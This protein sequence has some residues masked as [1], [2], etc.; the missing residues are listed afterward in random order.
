MER[1]TS[2][3]NI[4]NE[5]FEDEMFPQLSLNASSCYFLKL[6]YIFWNEH[7]QFENAMG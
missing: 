6:K 4:L 5:M 7:F 2:K 3:I 1:S